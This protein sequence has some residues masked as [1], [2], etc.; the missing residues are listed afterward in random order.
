MDKKKRDD[1]LDEMLRRNN[2][3][4]IKDMLGIG[5][6][7]QEKAKEEHEK[8]KLEMIDMQIKFLKTL[9]G[10]FSKSSK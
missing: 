2:Q 9:S 10:I 1:Y 4:L 6:P 8:R 3:K 7:E 5:T